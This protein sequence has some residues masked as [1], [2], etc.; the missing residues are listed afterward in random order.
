[1]WIRLLST[2]ATAIKA[3]DT[4]SLSDSCFSS[5]K[6]CHHVFPVTNP[7][8]VPVY[9]SNLFLYWPLSLV[10]ST[11]EWQPRSR[12]IVNL[13]DYCDHPDTRRHKTTLFRVYSWR[14]SQASNAWQPST[15]CH[16]ETRTIYSALS[17]GISSMPSC[18]RFTRHADLSQI[19]HMHGMN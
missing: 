16:T 13:L 2:L 3:Y 1:M 10:S 18:L 4:E 12:H 8:T 19:V 11:N 14:L 17:S 15:I 9:A 7:Q 5:S 6:Y